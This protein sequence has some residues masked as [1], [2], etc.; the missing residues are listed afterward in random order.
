[1]S[2]RIHIVH[3]YAQEMN[4]YGD[5]GNR[6]ILAHR[7]EC[8][9]Y[10]VQVSM[11]GV[12]DKLPDDAHIVLG[13]GGQDKGQEVVSADLHQKTNALIELRDRGVPM[14]MIC[15]MYQLFGAYFRTQDGIELPGASIVDAY[16]VASGKR[17]VG[18]VV[19]ESEFG[20]LVGYENHSGRTYVGEG[21]QPLARVVQGGGNNGQDGYEG[22]RQQNIIG[23]YMHGPVLAK[24]PKLADWLLQKAIQSAT[25]SAP[26]LNELPNLD[27][28][29]R[30]AADVAR[31]R[32]R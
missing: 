14:L 13:G 24:S 1:M 28:L 30:E 29:A 19:A 8:R 11:V 7:L 9:G 20:T 16:T 27:T 21:A 25:G 32:P 10:Q 12:G 31:R 26:E 17:L 23:T 5:T 6:I 18:N 2:V 3:L 4:I 15:G 22:L